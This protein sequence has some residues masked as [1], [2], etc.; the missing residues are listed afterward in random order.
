MIGCDAYYELLQLH[1]I[2][3]FTGVPDSLLKDFCACVSHNTGRRRDIVAANEGTAVALAA[4]HYMATG[5]F[6]LVYL[7]NSGLGN[8]VNPLAI[9]IPADPKESQMLDT[10]FQILASIWNLEPGIKNS[11][12]P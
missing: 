9:S 3:F 1:G 11:A 6:T 5:E 4:G 10:R 12:C 8:A 7:Q 2:A